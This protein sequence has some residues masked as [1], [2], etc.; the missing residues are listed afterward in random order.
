[1]GPEGRGFESLFTDHYK[2]PQ[3][4]DWGFFASVLFA[5]VFDFSPQF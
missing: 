2:K 4:K 1:M 5:S 3:S